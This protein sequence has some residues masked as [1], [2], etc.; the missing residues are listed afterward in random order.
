M[1]VSQQWIRSNVDGLP[2]DLEVSLSAYK[3]VDLS[4][5][6]ND[7]SMQAAR[8]IGERRRPIFIG[9]SGGM[10]SEYV[11]KVFI[12]CGIS[13][14]PIIVETTG[15]RLELSYAYSM[16]E[17]NSLRARVISMTEADVLSVYHDKFIPIS[18][19][20]HNAV[21]SYMAGMEAEQSG[22]IFVMAEHLIDEQPD[23]SIRVGANEWDF[24]NDRLINPGNTHY[25]FNYTPNISL[26]MVNLLDD[27][28]DAQSYKHRI[29][30]VP[31]RPK[32]KYE[33]SSAFNDVLRSIK[34]RIQPHNPSY[35][36]GSPGEYRR[37]IEKLYI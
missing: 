29:Y 9:M 13:F 15:N 20:G 36:F 27:S 30:D 35:S 17:R 3:G 32:M 5:S 22:G 11:I 34:R 7:A 6:F 33:Y 10:D 31:Y 2:C 19:Y 24:Y 28:D 1:S 12:E 26:S 14:T 21:P 8:M 25:F 4:M 18:A 23:G 16:L 37:K